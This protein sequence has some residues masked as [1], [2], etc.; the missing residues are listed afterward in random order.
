MDYF[1][2]LPINEIFVLII[3]KNKFKSAATE[4]LFSNVISTLKDSAQKKHRNETS[5]CGYRLSA[6]QQEI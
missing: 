6:T 3:Q 5:N 2:L 1:H 4:T